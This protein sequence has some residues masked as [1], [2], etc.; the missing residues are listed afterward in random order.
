M[1]RRF[2]HRFEFTLV[3]CAIFSKDNTLLIVGQRPCLP[4]FLNGKVT[5][6][7][8]A[9]GRLI[10]LGSDYP[11]TIPSIL[12][13][14]L[15]PQPQWLL[16]QLLLLLLL[17]LLLILQLPRCA[18]ARALV[19]TAHRIYPRDSE[20]ITY[21]LYPRKLKIGA[22]K[23]QKNAAKSIVFKAFCGWPGRAGSGRVGSRLSPL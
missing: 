2:C 5:A 23:C 10:Q 15:A 17:L 20:Q 14:P 9:W 4:F 3:L 8:A 7:L 6:L 1:P 22:K 21:F 19:K 12:Y 16:L 18:L 11:R 13:L